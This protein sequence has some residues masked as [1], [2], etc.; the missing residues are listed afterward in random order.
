MNQQNDCIQKKKNRRTTVTKTAKA[1]VAAAA[2][3]ELKFSLVNQHRCFRYKLQNKYI[4]FEMCLIFLFDHRTLLIYIFDNRQG[5]V[6]GSRRFVKFNC[7]LFL[8]LLLFVCIS[9][10]PQ[11]RRTNMEYINKYMFQR[12]KEQTNKLVIFQPKKIFAHT[13]THSTMTKD[14]ERTKQVLAKEI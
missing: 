5:V 3:T 2:A 8:S 7:M 1:A 4:L 11:W 9:S 13:H 6:S 10:G 14:H 12:C